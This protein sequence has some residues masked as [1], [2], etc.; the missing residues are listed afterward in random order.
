MDVE[1]RWND[2]SLS[3]IESSTSGSDSSLSDGL[4]AHLLN[5]AD[6]LDHKKKVYKKKK[7]KP[8]QTRKQ[9]NE[10]YQK[11]NMMQEFKSTEDALK[12]P[13]FASMMQK[14]PTFLKI[15]ENASSSTVKNERP[16]MNESQL[17]GRDKGISLDPPKATGLI[18]TKKKERKQR[19]KPGFTCSSKR[20]TNT[21]KEPDPDTKPDWSRNRFLATRRGHTT[22][23]VY[24]SLHIFTYP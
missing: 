14:Q 3:D 2:I 23:E 12:M 24:P 17:N 5:I 22:M 20:S 8:L 15:S 11:N 16:R 4:P 9:R 18:L 13:G 1:S 21:S 19:E 6:E 7:K 10:Q